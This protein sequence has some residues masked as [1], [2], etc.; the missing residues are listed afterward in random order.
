MVD[1]IRIAVIGL[2]FGQFHVQ[3]L[4]NLPDY[5]LVAVADR[6]AS[7]DLSFYEAK[8]N[9]KGYQNALEM[10]EQE[11]L[12]AV[13]ISTSPKGRAPLLEAALARKLA[14][15]VEKPWAT[16]VIQAR[17]WAALCQDA[18]VML[19]FSFR[20]LPVVQK[21]HALIASDLG[22]PWI[23][24]AAY[25]SSYLP[26]SDAW[27]WDAENGGGYF[28]ENSCHLLDI[29][30]YLMGESV[31]V[32]AK[33]TRFAGRP[34]EESA[35]VTLEFASGAAASMLFGGSGA[36]AHSNYPHLNLITAAGQAQLLGQDHIFTALHWATRDDSELRVLQTQPER[37]S[38][39]RYVNAFKHFAAC[40]R[41][42]TM[43]ESSVNDGVRAVKLAEAIYT[44]VRTGDA[45]RM[46]A[47]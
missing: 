27:V 18:P 34:S 15:F 32:Y 19:G 24:Q 4:A 42:G 6:S 13:V 3:T 7:R 17:Q 20:F 12:E 39:T 46:E 41:A 33:G 16:N 36:P 8:Y 11:E 23:A 21:L 47:T 2:G 10:L 30:T 45:I 29:L 43:P 40:I 5:R 44:S 38:E 37:L 35:A 26:P 31:S 9:L 22:Q 28:N 25:L 1:A 14:I